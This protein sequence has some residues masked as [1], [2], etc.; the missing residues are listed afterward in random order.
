MRPAI[1]FDCDG[2]LNEEPGGHGVL[3][4]TTSG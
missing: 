2:V 4:P 1:F 3:G